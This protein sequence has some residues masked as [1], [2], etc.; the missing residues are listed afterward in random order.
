MYIYVHI[1]KC[2]YK[3]LRFMYHYF[4]IRLFLRSTVYSVAHKFMLK[5]STLFFTVLVLD[6]AEDGGVFTQFKLTGTKNT[7]IRVYM[8]VYRYIYICLQLYI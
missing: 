8:Y 7:Y 5:F 4:L 3:Y 2:T 1:Y 6:D